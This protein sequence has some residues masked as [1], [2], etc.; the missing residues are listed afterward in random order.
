MHRK[1]NVS[2]SSRNYTYVSVHIPFSPTFPEKT[3][4]RNAIEYN[5]Y[6]LLVHYITSVQGTVIANSQ[7][8]VLD[9]L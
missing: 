3:G 7:E 2:K 9:I 5:Y 4:K 8:Q 1:I 6:T